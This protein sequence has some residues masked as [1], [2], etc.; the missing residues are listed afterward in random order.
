MD[1]ITVFAGDANN[2]WTF[3]TALVAAVSAVVV[4]VLA[5]RRKNNKKP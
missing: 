5:A 2:M 3:L 1:P 4:A